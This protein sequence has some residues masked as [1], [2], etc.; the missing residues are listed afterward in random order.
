[1]QSDLHAYDCALSLE[2]TSQSHPQFRMRHQHSASRENSILCMF[3][4]LTQHKHLKDTDNIL[5]VATTDGC[6]K[7]VYW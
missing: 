7:E 2:S 1:M 3:S 6:F 4:V 5:A